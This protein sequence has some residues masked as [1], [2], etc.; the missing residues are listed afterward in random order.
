MS[1][2]PVL[3]IVVGM[4][5]SSQRA[6]AKALISYLR[7]L[8][9]PMKI[10]QYD[11][12]RVLDASEASLDERLS[13]IDSARQNLSEALQAID[14]LAESAEA[15]KNELASL[16]AA[17]ARALQQKANVSDE[18]QQVRALASLDT[19]AVRRALD[20]PSRTQRW[21]ERLIAFLLGIGA[22][23]LASVLFEWLHRLL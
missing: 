5:G 20:V 12:T 14:Q 19:Q 10:G 7:D 8:G 9:F 22:S 11:L 13:K 21:V 3:A 17:V 15:Q 23:L 1:M 6:L 18:L 16:T 2:D 4:L